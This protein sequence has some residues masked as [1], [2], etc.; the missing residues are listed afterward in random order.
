MAD[1]SISLN[2][3]GVGPRVQPLS[4]I[5]SSLLLL[6]IGTLYY[7]EYHYLIPYVLKRTDQPYLVPYFWVWAGSM[8]LILAISVFLYLLEGHPFTWKVFATRYRLEQMPGKDWLWALAV[9]LVT[10]GCYFGLSGTT[11]WL[12]S[13]PVFTPHPLAPAELRPDAAGNLIPGHFFG[14]AI[15]GQ[16]WVVIVYFIGWI[17]NILGEEFFY[18]GWMLPRQELA[19]GRCAWLING[20][21]FTFQH[22][23]QPFNFLAIWPGAL[24]MAWVVQ[25]RR[26]TW[27]GILQHGLMNFSALVML[28]RWVIG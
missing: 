18:R 7:L 22:W 12:A 11:R 2:I 26:N 15:W 1:Q 5:P 17:F 8:G 13:M 6:F 21:M 3:E 16:W 27:I 10:A 25:R 9:L 24:F 14:M 20:T 28:V 23:M 4:W 19:F